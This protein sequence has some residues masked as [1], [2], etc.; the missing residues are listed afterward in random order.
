MA[1]GSAAFIF[2]VESELSGSDLKKDI[3]TKIVKNAIN[4][5]NKNESRRGFMNLNVEPEDYVVGIPQIYF[6][7]NSENLSTN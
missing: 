4:P 2:K 3:E 1:R 6:K 7:S 5:D